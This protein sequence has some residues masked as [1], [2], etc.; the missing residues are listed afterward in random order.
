MDGRRRY[1]ALTDDWT[2][3]MTARGKG[4][5]SHLRLLHKHYMSQRRAVVMKAPDPVVITGRR[6]RKVFGIIGAA[7]WP[8]F[9]GYVSMRQDYPIFVGGEAKEC[10]HGIRFQLSRI[11]PAQST[12]LQRLHEDGGVAWVWIRRIRD[13]AVGAFDDHVVPHQIISMWQKE[14]HRSVTWGDLMPWRVPPGLGWLDAVVRK[15][16]DGTEWVWDQFCD[17]GWVELTD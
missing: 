9:F 14:G 4:L 6:G 7:Y 3:A 5:E 11:D 15:R 10:S 16:K 1:T 8:D 12:A 17:G 13:A 2:D